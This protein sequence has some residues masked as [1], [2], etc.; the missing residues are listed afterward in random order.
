[1]PTTNSN[2]IQSFFRIYHSLIQP[3]Y[4]PEVQD[5]I[6]DEDI[7]NNSKYSPYFFSFSLIWAV[8][9]T[10][11]TNGHKIYDQWVRE[12]SQGSDSAFPSEGLVYDYKYDTKAGQW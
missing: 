5:H 11:D 4:S 7:R 10:T 2:V 1:M 8:E 3:F 9:S 12:Q 6:K